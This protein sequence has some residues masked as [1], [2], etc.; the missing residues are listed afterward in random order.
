LQAVVWQQVAPQT[1]ELVVAEQVL[2]VKMVPQTLATVAQVYPAHSQAQH[3]F[4]LAE[5][6][7]E[8]AAQ[9]EKVLEVQEWAVQD[10]TE[11]LL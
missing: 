9:E 3:N 1:T 7:A 10:E 11:A 8:Q 6:A 4:M 2:L 5:G